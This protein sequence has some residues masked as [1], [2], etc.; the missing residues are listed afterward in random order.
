MQLPLLPS[1]QTLLSQSF[2]PF[3]LSISSTRS[4]PLS[5]ILIV[6]D[7]FF[8]SGCSVESSPHFLLLLPVWPAS[9]L[10]VTSFLLC[11]YYHHITRPAGGGYGISPNIW[12]HRCV[13]LI[14]MSLFSPFPCKRSSLLSSSTASFSTASTRTKL[15]LLT[16]SLSRLARNPSHTHFFPICSQF[17][18]AMLS[19]NIECGSSNRSIPS[20]Y[21]SRTT[22]RKVLCI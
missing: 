14:N 1:S 10:C 4:L 6:H 21:E 20:H 12:H 15:C 13:S 9:L 5:R 22:Y 16:F 17:L 8:A 3:S 11:H 18:A 2:L 19:L 7:A